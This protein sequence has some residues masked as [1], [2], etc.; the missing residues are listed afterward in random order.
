MFGFTE[1]K[2]PNTRTKPEHFSFLIVIERRWGGFSPA[3]E[4]AYASVCTGGVKR[5]CCE[6]K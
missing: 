3:C 2:H 6:R 4:R 5:G 1:V